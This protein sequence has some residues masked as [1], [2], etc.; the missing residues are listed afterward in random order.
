[1]AALAISFRDRR[2]MV[3]LLSLALALTS[4]VGVFAGTAFSQPQKLTHHD[5]LT[6]LKQVA[7]AG[8][9]GRAHV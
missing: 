5:A 7:Y 3:R 6:A 8:Q 4:L 1:M 2:M 9:I